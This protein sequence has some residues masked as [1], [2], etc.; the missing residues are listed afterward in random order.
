MNNT[1][2]MD[3]FAMRSLFA[4]AV[5]M[6]ALLPASQAAADGSVTIG[7]GHSWT[8]SFGKVPFESKPT[9]S[10]DQP[11]IASV[12]WTGGESGSLVVTG[13]EEGE[14]VVTITG[15]VRVVNFGT[16][17]KPIATVKD[18]TAKVYVTVVED[19]EYMK[20]VI[21]HV[22]EKI[23]VKFPKNM[24]LSAKGIT[25]SN[26]KI[27]S[28]RRNSSKQLTIRGKKVGETWLR[29]KLLIS[30]KGK[31]DKEVPAT[32]KVRVI[33]GKPKKKYSRTGWDDLYIG[34]III[35][36]PG[37]GMD[38]YGQPTEEWKKKQKERE[39]SRLTDWPGQEGVV[40]SFVPSGRNYGDIGDLV[41]ENDSN[42]P[43]TVTVP[44][45]LL[46]DSGDPA[47]QDLYVADVP[48]ETVCDGAKEIGK[49]ITIEPDGM[50]VIKELPG[51]CPD[52]EKDP[53]ETDNEGIYACKQPDEK[54]E[55]LLDTVKLVKELDVGTMKLEVFEE[56]KARAMVAQGSLWMVDSEIDETK[57]NEVSAKDL[58][59]KFF[60]SFAE[61]AKDKLEAM[62]PEKREQVEEL[63]KDDIKKIVEATSFVAK[64]GAAGKAKKVEV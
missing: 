17:N 36:N 44:E 37:V 11:N 2:K 38:E 41:I 10:V 43:V 6:A 45:G 20:L 13:V 28:V 8:K 56:D 59:E 34:E 62:T 1:K 35:V 57:G 15:K 33:A 47:V 53:P 63:V 48:T 31:K 21:L 29:F 40:C 52:F 46:L 12:S 61:S 51:F 54:A 55:A 64:K 23:S 25:N 22:K 39:V 14:A 4:A 9:I 32:I 19:A 27:A 60:G 24:K 7:V 5:C 30:K 49:P 3:K 16:G 18:V 50:Y 58:S 26:P 42:K